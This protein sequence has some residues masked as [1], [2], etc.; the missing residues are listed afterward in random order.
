MARYYHLS[1]RTESRRLQVAA[2]K[3]NHFLLK[4]PTGVT[5]A[6]LTIVSQGRVERIAN[7]VGGFGSYPDL[8]ISCRAIPAISIPS[9]I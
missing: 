8:A 7:W 1:N 4:P 9:S 3:N 5:V 2:H 6:K